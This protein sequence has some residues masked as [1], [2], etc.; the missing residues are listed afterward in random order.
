V[1]NGSKSFERR[2][3]LKKHLL[4]P[5]VSIFVILAVF[6]WLLYRAFNDTL[7]SG[8]DTTMLLVIPCFIIIWN[9]KKRAIF[10]LYGAFL[11]AA[12]ICTALESIQTEQPSIYLLITLLIGTLLLPI[13]TFIKTVKKQK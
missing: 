4:F 9:S 3:L 12:A 5:T 1:Y 10:P 11:L 8:S 6:G 7:F 13:E 2:L